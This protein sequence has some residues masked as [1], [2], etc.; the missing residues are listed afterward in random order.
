MHHVNSHPNIYIFV[1]YLKE[2]YHT[3]V[4]EWCKVYCEFKGSFR[5][6]IITKWKMPGSVLIFNTRKVKE[7]DG[8][9]W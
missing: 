6:V 9:L 7:V 8:D 2:I 1:R 3:D 4:C 5:V